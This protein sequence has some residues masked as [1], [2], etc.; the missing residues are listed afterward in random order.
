MKADEPTKENVSNSESERE[1]TG[2]IPSPLVAEKIHEDS[3]FV[4]KKQLEGSPKNEHL[5]STLGR[6]QKKCRKMS[7]AYSTYHQLIQINPEHYEACLF[8]GSYYYV[9]GK[10]MLDKEDSEYKTIKNPK[11]MQYAS[12]QNNVRKIL[13][14]KYTLAAQYLESALSRKKTGLVVNTLQAIYL[15]INYPDPNRR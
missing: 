10:K 13:D 15:R 6:L 12:Y 7:D 9:H 11:R 14:E 8:L 2:F 4:I 5:L 3:I 1:G